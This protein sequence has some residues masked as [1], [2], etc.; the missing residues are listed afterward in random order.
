MSCRSNRAFGLFGVVDKGAL[1]KWQAHSDSN[2]L[3]LF[4]WDNTTLRVAVKSV[5]FLLFTFLRP[6]QV[7]LNFSLMW[8]LEQGVMPDGIAYST[9]LFQKKKKSDLDSE[10]AEVCPL[11]FSTFML[12]DV[13][14]RCWLRY[15]YCGHT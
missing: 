15:Y 10:V 6:L 2:T 8:E 3:L 11:V 9:A 14:G 4:D 7:E 1:F 5:F 12:P 13:L